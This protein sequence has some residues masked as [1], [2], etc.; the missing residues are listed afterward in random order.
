M[1]EAKQEILNTLQRLIVDYEQ[2]EGVN[3]RHIEEIVEYLEKHQFKPHA[4]KM[5][6]YIDDKIREIANELVRDE[7]RRGD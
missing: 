5:K 2:L 3:W 7:K 4:A 6:A 1:I